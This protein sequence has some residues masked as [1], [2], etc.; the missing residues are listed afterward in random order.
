MLDRSLDILPEQKSAVT[1]IFP[2][3]GSQLGVADEAIGA[4]LCCAVLSWAGQEKLSLARLLK[5]TFYWENQLGRPEF[6][7]LPRK[8]S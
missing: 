3:K 7:P 1:F 8:H 6:V 5:R 2:Q 4:V